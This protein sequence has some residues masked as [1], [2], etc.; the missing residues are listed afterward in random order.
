M[1]QDLSLGQSCN[2][3]L[4]KDLLIRPNRF[5]TLSKPILKKSVCF[6]YFNLRICFYFY[7]VDIVVALKMLWFLSIR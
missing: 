1:G 3:E 7:F 2:V 6:N 4:K 5:L